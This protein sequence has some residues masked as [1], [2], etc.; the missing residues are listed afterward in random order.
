MTERFI[1]GQMSQP[2]TWW[3]FS[4][5]TQGPLPNFCLASIYILWPTSLD[6]VCTIP[7]VEQD[8]WQ[9]T[10]MTNSCFRFSWLRTFLSKCKLLSWRGLAHSKWLFYIFD[11]SCI[12]IESREIIIILIISQ[13]KWINK[14]PH[15]GLMW[16][17]DWKSKV[18]WKQ[19]VFLTLILTIQI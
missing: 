17:C 6:G 1:L 10:S 12:N 13:N 5:L 4:I 14:T 8:S 15:R 9:H 3:T 16:L 7:V 2:Q 11:F 19:K 18:H